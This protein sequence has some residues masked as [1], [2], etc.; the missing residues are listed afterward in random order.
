MYLSSLR[1]EIRK[2][3]IKKIAEC[4]KV[5]RESF[6]TVAKEFGFIHLWAHKS[7]RFPFTCGFMEKDL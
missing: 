7:E 6:G 5:I 4:V 2:D 3:T 1:E